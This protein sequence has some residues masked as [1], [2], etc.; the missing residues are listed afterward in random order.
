MYATYT[1]LYPAP[2]TPYLYQS[3]QIE[4]AVDMLQLPNSYFLHTPS[5]LVPNKW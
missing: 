1:F 5:T 3:N 2:L 4:H